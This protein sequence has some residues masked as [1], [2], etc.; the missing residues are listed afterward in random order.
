MENVSSHGSKTEEKNV[1]Q[2]LMHL[3]LSAYRTNTDNRNKLYWL[4]EI[5][6]K[7]KLK[8]VVTNYAHTFNVTNT[9]V[10]FYVQYIV[11]FDTTFTEN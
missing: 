1:S 6:N 11:T 7:T 4:F 9:N 3:T 10:D 8:I 5:G 2:I